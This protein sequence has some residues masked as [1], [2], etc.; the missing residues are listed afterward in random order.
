M[1]PGWTPSCGVLPK[2]PKCH[3]ARPASGHPRRSLAPPRAPPPRRIPPPPPSR[4]PRPRPRRSR[5]RHSLRPQAADE[6]AAA[7]PG[8]GR[9]RAEPEPKPELELAPFQDPPRVVYRSEDFAA[10]PGRVAPR[11]RPAEP[12][13]ATRRRPAP[14][15]AAPPPPVSSAQ[16]REPPK[17]AG[18]SATSAPCARA[19]QCNDGCD[20][21]GPLPL[22]PLAPHRCPRDPLGRRAAH[23]ARCK[24]DRLG[25]PAQGLW[26]PGR[27][28]SRMRRLPP[29]A[30]CVALRSDPRHR[31]V[32]AAETGRAHASISL[33]SEVGFSRRPCRRAVSSAAPVGA[34]RR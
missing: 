32:P 7:E 29:P 15:V 27:L 20:P 23:G 16:R 14:G 12:A 11:A 19:H 18:G 1:L 4:N 25:W 31:V 33:E 30:W 21:Q 22:Q 13:P 28:A 5:I 34:R 8:P 2:A 6:G 24:L 17:S 3:A 26:P 10:V 9:T